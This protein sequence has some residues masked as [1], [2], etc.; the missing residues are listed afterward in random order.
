MYRM[1]R[2]R[3]KSTS[4]AQGLVPAYKMVLIYR[5]HGWHQKGPNSCTV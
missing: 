3:D 4:T 1:G 5:L 2:I